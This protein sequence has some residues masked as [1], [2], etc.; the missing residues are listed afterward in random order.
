MSTYTENPGG[1]RRVRLEVPVR[2]FWSV[3][4]AWPGDKVIMNVETAYLPDHTKFSVRVREDRDG[5]VADDDFIDEKKG[6]ELVNNRAQVPYTI[7]WDKASLGK[8]LVLVGDRCEF[9]FEVRIESPRVRGVS[10]LLYVH[11]H[12]YVVSG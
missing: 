11:L 8:K 2:A 4:R 12:P 3:P 1:L 10:N 9:V 5:P 7:A 6:L